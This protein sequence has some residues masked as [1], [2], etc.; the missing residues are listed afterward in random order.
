MGA[1]ETE[2]DVDVSSE[3]ME[4]SFQLV[5][6]MGWRERRPWTQRRGMGDRKE[7]TFKGRESVIWVVFFS[8]NFKLFILYWGIVD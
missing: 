8:P 6:E 3:R 5:G 7:N 1:C 2:G 4:P